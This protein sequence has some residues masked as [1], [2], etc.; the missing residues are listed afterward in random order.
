MTKS[1]HILGGSLTKGVIY[2]STP[3]IFSMVFQSLFNVVDAF[4][5]GKVGSV[6]I[7]AVSVS[8][9]IIFI[10]IALAS[11]LGIGC[12][13]LV[14]RYFGAKDMSTVYRVIRS[15][16]LLGLIAALILTAAGF[17]FSPMLFRFMGAEGLLFN[18]ALDYTYIIFAG[19]IVLVLPFVLAAVLRGEGDTKTP[20]KIAIGMNTLNM[21]LDPIFIFTFDWGVKGA[22]IATVASN[23]IGLIVYFWLFQKYRP[24]VIRLPCF[25]FKIAK[26]VIFIGFPASLRNIANAV[27]VFFIT[28][29]VTGYGTNV[30][31]AWGIGSRIQSFGILPVVAITAATITI[32]GQNLGA[33]NIKRAKKSAWVS[34]ALGMIIMAVFGLFIFAFSAW[35]IKFFNNELGVVKIGSLM[36]KIRVP[37]FVFMAAIMIIAS[38]FQA[39]GKAHYSFIIT[40]LRVIFMIALAYWLNSLWGYIGVWWAIT[41]S[42]VVLAAGIALWYELW[43]PKLI[44]LPQ[45]I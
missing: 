43:Q 41:I 5:L 20:M 37:A 8:W 36:L 4:W 2:L 15:S 18:Y 34:T 17:I 1:N 22:A 19:V 6:A 21:I 32:V 9:P 42:S 24:E 35:A 39:F 16:L 25:D 30:V 29:I 12:N 33:G 7:A 44:E 27:G 45:K 13:A 28:K 38:A 40:S 10:T 14:A 23:I 26:E 3:I 11:G 31:A